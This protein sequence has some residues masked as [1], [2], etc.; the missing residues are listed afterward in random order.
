MHETQRQAMGTGEAKGMNEPA[1]DVY[2]GGNGASGMTRRKHSG[3]RPAEGVVLRNSTRGTPRE[4][5][6]GGARQR[7]EHLQDLLRLT[8]TGSTHA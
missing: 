1:R 7:Y 4:I 6:Q 2:R 8:K 5:R 3:E